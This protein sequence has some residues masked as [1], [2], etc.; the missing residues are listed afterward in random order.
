MAHT[1]F[2]FRVL[3]F[4]VVHF[5]LRRFRGGFCFTAF[6][7]MIRVPHGDPA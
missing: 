4:P 3:T 6:E 2:S 7:T 1:A 5:P